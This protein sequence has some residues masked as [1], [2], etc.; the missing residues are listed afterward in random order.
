MK[1]F[2]FVVAVAAAFAVNVIV[3]H[4]AM[5]DGLVENGKRLTTTDWCDCD[6]D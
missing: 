3:H 6:V 5:G 4:D 1:F 2:S